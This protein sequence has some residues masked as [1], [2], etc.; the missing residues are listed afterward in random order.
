M[1]TNIEDTKSVRV[2]DEFLCFQPLSF[3]LKFPLALRK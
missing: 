2:S 3:K 1:S